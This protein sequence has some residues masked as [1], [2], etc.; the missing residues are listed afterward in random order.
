M[1]A[2]SR[3]SPLPI[4]V[5]HIETIR[6][7]H[8]VLHVRD[9]VEHYAVPMIFGTIAFTLDFGISTRT[10]TALVTVTGL[11]AAFFFTLSI[12]ILG[13]AASLFETNPQPG[14]ATTQ[15]ALLLEGLSANAHY[16]ALVAILTSICVLI[17]GILR[18]GWADRIFTAVTVVLLV[19]LVVTILFVSIR[20]FLLT[21]SRIVRART[22]RQE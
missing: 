6:D 5:T 1:G 17:V 4:L 3:I 20:V 13:R 16:S 9:V 7:S 10:V 12:N 18:R 15:Y 2:R 14:R 19:H 11:F 21:R 8:G 22:D